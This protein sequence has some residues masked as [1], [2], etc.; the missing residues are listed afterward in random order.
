MYQIR[1]QS[2]GTLPFVA[3]RLVACEQPAALPLDVW[4]AT[5]WRTVGYL[6]FGVW[7]LFVA[8]CGSPATE[9]SDV[10]VEVTMKPSPP[11]VGNSSLS[12]RL[13]D[14]QGKPIE[15]A[16]VRVEGNMNHAGM[17]PSFAEMREI[18]PGEYTGMLDFTM[19]GDWF[20]L[21][22]ATTTDGNLLERK[23]DVPGVQVQ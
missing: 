13:A 11:V 15:G 23:I 1:H 2:A 8:G 7:G 16:D 4:R 10:Q 9:T 20:L 21:I 6:C 19:G 14:A 12:L 17:K 22:T 5:A 18:E 3:A